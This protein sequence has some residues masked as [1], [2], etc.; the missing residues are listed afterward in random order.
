MNLSVSNHLILLDVRSFTAI[1]PI[2]FCISFHESMAL[3][4]V[5]N[6]PKPLVL[7][8]FYEDGLS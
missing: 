7:N 6:F 2:W 1:S 8:D 4:M 3:R 5:E